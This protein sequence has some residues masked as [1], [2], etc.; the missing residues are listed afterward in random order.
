MKVWA[1]QHIPTGKW[2]PCRMFRTSRAGWSRWDPAGSSAE[3]PHDQNP[4]IFFT[5]RAAANAL[6]MWLQGMWAMAYT[7]GDYFNPP[8]PAR[9]AP[10]TPPTPRRREDMKIVVGELTL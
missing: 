3:A 5:E 7:E 6:A 8:E 10:S 1:I 9:L 2:M 4:R